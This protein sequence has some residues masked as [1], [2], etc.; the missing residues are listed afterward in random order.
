[1]GIVFG[2]E[3]TGLSNK[4][5]EMCDFVVTIPTSVKYPSMNLSHAATIIFYEI[6]KAHGTGKIGEQIKIAD[7]KTK[8]HLL[9]LINKRLDSMEFATPSKKK[10]QQVIWKKIIGKSFL[11]RREAFALM[12]FFKKFK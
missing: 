4:E 1:V 8:E 2:R 12:G 10:T 3:G 9:K 6:F 11:S 5:V 7:K